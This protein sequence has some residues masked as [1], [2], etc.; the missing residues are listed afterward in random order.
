MYRFNWLLVTFLIILGNSF[1]ISYWRYEFILRGLLQLCWVLKLQRHLIIYFSIWLQ[2]LMYWFWFLL[3]FFG[4]FIWFSVWLSDF[5]LLNKRELFFQIF[6]E[7]EWGSEMILFDD[8]LFIFS[9]KIF[10]CKRGV[11]EV[12]L[13]NRFEGNRNLMYFFMTIIF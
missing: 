8:D 10:D 6:D 9:V 1:D 5:G 12:K 11:F 13:A 3:G 4:N 2:V 7:F